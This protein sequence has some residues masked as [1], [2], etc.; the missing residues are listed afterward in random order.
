MLYIMP[1]SVVLSVSRPSQVT[2]GY[3]VPPSATQSHQGQSLTA[4]WV[5][6]LPNPGHFLRRHLEPVE[7][8]YAKD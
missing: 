1:A 6:Q 5:I 3:L 8:E 7:D 2:A 4:N